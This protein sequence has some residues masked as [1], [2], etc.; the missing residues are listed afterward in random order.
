MRCTAIPLLFLNPLP[1]YHQFLTSMTGSDQRGYWHTTSN[2]RCIPVDD[3]LAFMCLVL[4]LSRLRLQEPSLPLP[5]RRNSA[6]HVVGGSRGD[7]A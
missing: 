2:K 3:G 6:Q 7:K 5:K 1:T 4:G